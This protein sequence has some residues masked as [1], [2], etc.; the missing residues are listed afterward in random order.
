MQDTQTKTTSLTKT[1]E[2][3]G[4]SINKDET[5]PMKLNAI[6]NQPITIHGT[7]ISKVNK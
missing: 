5:R 1:A 6:S 3:I 2:K 4:L 7:G